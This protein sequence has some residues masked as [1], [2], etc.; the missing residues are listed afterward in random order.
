MNFIFRVSLLPWELYRF[1]WGPLGAAGI[2]VP[3]VRSGVWKGG[4]MGSLTM[5]Q[6]LDFKS[7]NIGLIGG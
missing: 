7:A 1:A 5:V 4:Q 6:Q 2:R 3:D